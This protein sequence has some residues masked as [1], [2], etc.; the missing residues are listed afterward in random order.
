MSACAP[1]IEKTGK[2]VGLSEV[3]LGSVYAVLY[4]SPQAST[5]GWGTGVAQQAK[6][7]VAFI[8]ADGS[9]EL[10]ANEGMDSNAV[11]WTEDGLFYSDQSHDYLLQPGQEP[12]VFT[13]PKTEY[14]DGLVTLENGSRV[15]AFNVGF[16]EDGYLEEVVINDGSASKKKN[17]GRWATLIAACGNSVFSMDQNDGDVGGGVR[18]TSTLNWLVRDG[19]VYEGVI[20]QHESLFTIT[21]FRS[22][23]APCVDDEVFLLASADISTVVDDNPE[24]EPSS[25]LKSIA[26]NPNEAEAVAKCQ[27]YT[28]DTGLK[29]CP[30]IERWNTQSGERKIIPVLDQTGLELDLTGDFFDWSL[31]DSGS[32]LDGDLYW[33]HSLGHLVKTDLSSGATT[34]VASDPVRPKDKDSAARYFFQMGRN[35]A[36][37]LA[38]P[39]A[40]EPDNPDQIP[41]ARLMVFK[42]D[43]GEL[44]TEITVPGLSQSVNVDLVARGFAI[45]PT[46]RE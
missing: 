22:R 27:I 23:A 43:N 3:D 44:T 37:V 1:A 24:G 20:A 33:W 25:E 38:I 10:V 46:K 18:T 42:L 40:D 5:W 7:Y 14:Q 6:G 34:L 30:T 9:Y 32:V 17:T 35:T 45:N 11:S 31:Y 19:E 2:V 21:G 8:K 16:T 36:H 13:S 28:S 26:G 41:Q 39:Y 29:S 12:Q 15:G 4:L